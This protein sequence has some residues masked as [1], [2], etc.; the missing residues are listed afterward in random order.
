M[1]RG[2]L[3][4]QIEAGI[5]ALGQTLPGGACPRLA[6]LLLELERWGRRVNL[7]AMREPSAMVAGHLLDSLAARP[8]LRGRRLLDVGCGAGFP[9]LPLAIAEPGLEVVLLDSSG[10]K[11][12]FVRHIIAALDLDNAHAVQARAEDYSPP[13][14]FDTVI[15]RAFAGIPKIVAVAG[16]LVS[17]GGC[18]LA[19]KGKYPHDELQQLAS[20][21]E[22][23][24]THE[25]IEVTVPGLDQHARHVVRLERHGTGPA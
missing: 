17:R 10:K 4:R 21:C 24:W 15:A 9:G 7:T 13:E 16:H 5:A 12:A 25:V 22:S 18:L 23:G 6:T 8:F 14:P 19:L 3:E 2:E 11:I 20:T 1:E